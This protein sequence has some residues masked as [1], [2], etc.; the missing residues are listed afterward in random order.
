MGAT[1]TG[2][3]ELLMKPID[4]AIIGGGCAGLALA[5]DI[6]RRNEGKQ[7]GSKVIVFEPR[8][9]YEND[10]TWCYWSLAGEADD[11]LV[12]RHWQAW[13]FSKDG[14]AVR[15]RS[16]QSRYCLVSGCDFYADAIATIQRSDSLDLK[17]GIEVK[18]IESCHGGFKVTTTVGDY[19]AR[20]VVD[21]RPPSMTQGIEAALYQAFEGVEIETDER[22][23]DPEIASLMAQMHTDQNGFA[24]DYLLPLGPKRWLVE[25]TLFSPDPGCGNDLSEKLQACLHRI[26]PDGD[27]RC[28]KREKGMIP[29]GYRIPKSESHAG[30]V[31]AG[32]AGGA[33]RAASGYAYRRIQRWSQEC[34]RRFTDSGEVLG[35]PE[36]SWA[37][38]KMD[39]I[40]LKVL[41]NEPER[42]PEI[43]I[44]LARGISAD[45]MARFM[46]D[47]AT[48]LDL[49]AVVLAVPKKPFLRNLFSR[50]NPVKRIPLKR[51][52]A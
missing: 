25:A 43:F 7:D 52:P 15:Q 44:R 40:F 6:A 21:T 48:V 4:L 3:Q 13:Q 31:R 22:I 11:P 14:E 39:F 19:L 29:M 12:S 33:V 41:R 18:A 16:S 46:M 8:T 36:D 35:H 17:L 49:L 9:H 20:R 23:G 34:A 51:D 30:W 5:R 50:D 2:W 27:F 45:A 10:R 32:T 47:R 42:A 1:A 26:I 24:F 28:L 37:R 38:R